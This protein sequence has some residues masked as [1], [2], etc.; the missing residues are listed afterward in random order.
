MAL[1]DILDQVEYRRVNLAELN[2]PVFR[3]RYDAYRREDFIP[4]NQ[5]EIATDELDSVPNGMCYGI[6][7]SGELVSSIRLHHL[8]AEHRYSPSMTAYADILHPMLDRGMH[9]IDPSRFTADRDAALAFP[10]LPFLTLRLAAMACEYF[11]PDYC[12]S[13]IRQEH[14]AFYKRVF[15]SEQWAGERYLGGGLKFPVCLYAASY[16]EIRDRVA[17]RFP[18]FMSTPEEREAMFG[19]D[20]EAR[21]LTMIQP[22]AR[23]AALA[24]HRFAPAGE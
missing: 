6:Y 11:V 3:L 13:S 2:D 21:F 9:F 7:I 24:E 16:S 23:A 19:E 5:D 18:F 15:G 4:A 8:T 10:A 22:T 1:M 17:D 14:A 12:L 20:D